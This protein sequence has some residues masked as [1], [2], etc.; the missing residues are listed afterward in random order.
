MA[1][2][3]A[4]DGEGAGCGE[5][6]TTNDPQGTCYGDSGGPNI[7]TIDGVEFI[8]GVTSRG[9]DICG[10]G[11]DVAVRVD[12]RIDWIRSYILEND[13]GECGSDNRCA[14]GCVT[15]DIDCCVN[16]GRCIEECGNSD[17]ELLLL[18]LSR[19]RKLVGPERA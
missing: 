16:D 6:T 13:A 8:A 11:L 15:I 12:E 4:V 2:L 17:P 14:S 19:A 1:R 7:M 9:T 10:A 18:G 5:L 3:N